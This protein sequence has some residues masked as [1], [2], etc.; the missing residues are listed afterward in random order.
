MKI[1]LKTNIKAI[2]ARSYVRIVAANREPSWWFTETLLPILSTAAYV[3]VYKALNA[4]EEYT[5]F[6]ILG[7][8]M[9]AYWIHV[10]W[11]MAAQ[12]YWEKEIGN[13]ELYMIAPI[14]RMSILLGM[15]SGGMFLATTRAVFIFLVGS[16][17][18][19][20]D[21]AIIS[22]PKLF[23][24]FVLTL[25]GLYGLG[26]LFSSL[27]ML[28]GR[29]AWHGV[30]L[31]QEPVH[32]MSGFFFPVRNLGFAVALGAS[33]IPMTLGLDAM[34]QLAFKTGAK[35][36]FISADV[37]I[38]ALV[39]LCVL[40]LVVSKYALEYMEKLGKKEGRLTLRWQ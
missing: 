32:L 27:F 17:I 26:M 36:G 39:G 29:E 10:L 22:L 14:S 24:V 3:Y 2:I 15:A 23:A 1:D 9:S 12:F 20:V 16:L 33:L 13:L 25:V 8:T 18:F 5:G 6:V 28:Y 35:S 11:S 34:R 30:T 40:F 37:E 38:A 4:P 21:F 19:K 7:G 31:L